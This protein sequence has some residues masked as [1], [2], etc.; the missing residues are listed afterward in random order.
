LFIWAVVFF[1]E[2]Q[3][4]NTK[5]RTRCGLCLAGACLTR[6]D[7]WFLAAAMAAVVIV[8]AIFYRE[9]GGEPRGRK[10]AHESKQAAG[11]GSGMLRFVLVF[12][13]LAGAAPVLW[14]AY[15]GIVYGNPLE[16]E[17]GPYSAQAIERK[18]QVEE[19][20]VHRS[21]DHPGSG[22]PLLA[23]MYFVKSA[24]GN[25]ADNQWLGRGWI[26]IAL[27]AVVAAAFALRGKQESGPVVW[28]L[29]FLFV[30]L[31]FYALSIAYGGVPI[32]IPNWWPFSY[33]NVR[34]GLQLVPAFA[35]AAAILVYLA[36]RSQAFD[37]RLR[38]ACGFGVVAVVVAG[39]VSIWRDVP[40]CLKEAQVNMHSRTQLERELAQWIE[41]LPADSTLLMY[42]GDHVGAVERAGLPLRH[43][44]NEGNHRVW[45]QPADLD[46]LWERAL[47]NPAQYADFVLAFEGDPV[48]QAVHERHLDEVVEIRVTGQARAVLYR[49]R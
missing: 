35:M 38:M 1:V 29:L 39:Y 15:N 26:L 5:A 13:L 21:P 33:Y 6:Y 2:W 27:G 48:W 32:F 24:E 42:L 34:Y 41:K 3:R 43:T 40:I 49:A 14:L 10:H 47:A 46:G 18:T 20:P 25:M 7:G 22:N 23:G 37:R 44:I 9:G 45:K 8:R 11:R 4:G 19:S 17:N 30:P 16:F 28:P 12:V 36:I 31:L